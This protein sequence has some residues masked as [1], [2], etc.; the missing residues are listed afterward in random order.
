MEEVVSVSRNQYRKLH[1]TKSWDFVGLPL[2]AKR[3][4]KAERDVII[5]V[6]DTGLFFSICKLIR[7]YSFMLLIIY[8]NLPIIQQSGITP[9][10]ESFLDHGLGPPPAKWKGSCGPYKNFTGCNKYT[11]YLLPFSTL[12]DFKYKL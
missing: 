4:L 12:I 7:Y 10:S 6:L 2:T 11:I 1:T 5:G 3:H 9:D 8:L